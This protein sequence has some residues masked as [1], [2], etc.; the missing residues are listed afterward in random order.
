[1]IG[2]VGGRGAGAG[3]SPLLVDAADAAEKVMARDRRFDLDED[4]LDRFM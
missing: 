3:G 4:A 2:G 1:M